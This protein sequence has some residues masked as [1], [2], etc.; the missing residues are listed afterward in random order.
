MCLVAG[1]E[2]IHCETNVDEC[3]S[4]PCQNGATCIDGTNE[5]H[6]LCPDGRSSHQTLYRSYRAIRVSSLG[7]GGLVSAPRQ[8]ILKTP[9]SGT[10]FYGSNDP[11]NNVK[12]LKEDRVIKIRLQSHTVIQHIRG[13]KKHSVQTQMNPG[14]VK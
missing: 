4:S 14:T 1:F 10:G 2:G 7:P 6:C 13:T 3:R 12:A 8:Q 5:F 9:R 11:T